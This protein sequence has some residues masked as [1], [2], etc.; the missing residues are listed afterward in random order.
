MQQPARPAPAARPMTMATP[1][2]AAPRSAAVPQQKGGMIQSQWAPSSGYVPAKPPAQ[3]VQTMPEEQQRQPWTPYAEQPSA[4]RMQPHAAAPA[5]QE[6]STV[7]I[8]QDNQRR[9]NAQR[10]PVPA[11]AAPEK[12]AKPAAKPAA[13]PVEKTQERDQHESR[14]GYGQPRY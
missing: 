10:P 8:M 7:R 2:V 11:K 14:E 12:S 6:A 9:L 4:V 5:V 1:M 3:K 13:K